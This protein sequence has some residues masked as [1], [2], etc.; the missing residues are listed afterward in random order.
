MRAAQSSRL[1]TTMPPSPV[2]MI[3]RGWN[4]NT[5]SSAAA[6]TGAPS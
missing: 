5:A 3:L 2:V 6:P 4:E 1:V